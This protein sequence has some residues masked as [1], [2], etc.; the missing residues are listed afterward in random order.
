[1]GGV[2]SARN[3]GL[4]NARGEWV[5]FVDAD[6]YMSTD[7][8]ATLISKNAD[9][10]VG[11]HLHYNSNGEFWEDDCTLP[12]TDVSEKHIL[13][14][15]LANCMVYNIMRT[16]WAKLFKRSLVG[17]MKFDETMK[18]GEDTAF[19]QQYLA[20]C[21]SIS[22]V[23]GSDYYYYED[24]NKSE[25]YAMTPEEAVYH[26]KRI[27]LH[28]KKLNIKSLQF[29]KFLLEYFYSLCKNKMRYHSDKW[30]GD[31][32]IVK[33][34]VSLKTVVTRKRYLRI[35]LMRIPVLYDLWLYRS[36]SL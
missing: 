5:T 30:F 2:S 23:N 19:M 14:Q 35:Q 11:H 33:L 22:V 25:K 29:E 26:L 8:F 28:Y 24:D 31:D 34:I 13:R 17:N 6:D 27:F 7:F 32:L 21:N 4:G 36:K 15:F 1:M 3:V 18:C 12:V 9:L 10:I 16:P 20:K